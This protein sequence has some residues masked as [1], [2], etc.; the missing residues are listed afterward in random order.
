[1]LVNAALAETL[2]WSFK[3]YRGFQ[4]RSFPW[5]SSVAAGA[6][7]GVALFY[8]TTLLSAAQHVQARTLS[9]GVVQPNV[10]QAQKWDV[11]FRQET[12]SRFDRLTTGLGDNLD[13]IVWPEAATPFVYEMEPQYRAYTL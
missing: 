5:P 6:G 8:G 4:I 11:A 2:I 7:F 12:M 1:M 10:E 13:L 9:V 3:A